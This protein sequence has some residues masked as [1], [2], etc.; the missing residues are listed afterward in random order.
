M[1]AAHAAPIA[2][3]WA[4]ASSPVMRGRVSVAVAIAFGLVAETP[5]DQS[6]RTSLKRYALVDVC[7]ASGL[8]RWAATLRAGVVSE[9]LSASRSSDA[10]A[11]APD[12]DTG[13][14]HRERDHEAQRTHLVRVVAVSRERDVGCAAPID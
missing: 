9:C 4:W 14:D 13:G 1:G 12:R 8:G 6:W 3:D 10:R 7:V 2:M 11:T 5:S